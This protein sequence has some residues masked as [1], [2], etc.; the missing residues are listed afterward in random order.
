MIMESVLDK[1]STDNNDQIR[2][3]YIEPTTRCNLSCGMCPRNTWT[4]EKIGDMDMG[5]FEKLIDQIKNIKSI[6]TIFFGGVAEPMSHKDIVKMVKMSKELGVRV[7]LI[8]NGSLLD[9][10]KVEGLLLAGLDMLW[11]SIDKAHSDS[12]GKIFGKDK[13]DKTEKNLFEFRRLKEKIN[14]D[15]ELG[16]AFV[17]MKSNIDEFPNII[18]IATVMG[19]SEIKVSN[20]IPYTEEMQDE[21]LY[22]RSI[23]CGAFRD[24]ASQY[25]RKLINLPIM[26]FE[27]IP[28]NVM[29]SIMRSWSDIKLGKNKIDRDAGHCMFIQD[30]SLFIRWDGEVSPCIALLHNNKTYIQNVERKIRHCSYGNIKNEKLKNI[31]EKEE[32]S[33]FRKRVK[34]FTF[35]PCTRCGVCEYTEGNEEDCY[36]NT[37]P[38]CGACLWAE[39]FSQCP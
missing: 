35:S 21:I 13:A 16:I 20:L 3:V 19:A 7:E 8:S 38:T 15:A 14:P 6:E 22:D 27:L 18:D 39:G 34:E 30:D 29:T 1:V 36:G 32:Y 2:K 26:D 28:Q 37:F 5:L 23:S 17:A 4:D 10:D 12:T 24:D 31:W 9:E 33:S 11:V 25:K